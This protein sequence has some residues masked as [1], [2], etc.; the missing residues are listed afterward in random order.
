MYTIDLVQELEHN[1]DLRRI[2]QVQNS[3]SLQHQEQLQSDLNIS[4]IRQM[5]EEYAGDWCAKYAVKVRRLR[6]RSHA[7]SVSHA[8]IHA[9]PPM[10]ARMVDRCYFVWGLV[11]VRV[12]EIESRLGELQVDSDTPNVFGNSP[13]YVVVK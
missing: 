2:L 6:E 3:T 4:L 10:R 1:E 7:I 5:S 12:D 11:D 13:L 8:L 9:S